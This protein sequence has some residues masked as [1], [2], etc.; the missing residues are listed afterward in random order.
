MKACDLW[1]HL[2]CVCLLLN[3]DPQSMVFSPDRFFCPKCFHQKEQDK[4]PDIIE[5]GSPTTSALDVQ[6]ELDNNDQKTETTMINLGMTGDTV[7]EFELVRQ[8]KYN[9]FDDDMVNSLVRNLHQYI[10]D[11]DIEIRSAME[12]FATV[13]DVRTERPLE[14]WKLVDANDYIT[15]GQQWFQTRDILGKQHTCHAPITAAL[16]SMLRASDGKPLVI[17]ASLKNLPFCQVHIG[18]V[19]WFVFDIL[20]NGIDLHELPNMRSMRAMMTAV[21]SAGEASKHTRILSR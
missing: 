21:A 3:E 18:L 6:S 12:R 7:I 8:E 1:C 4:K 20:D 17:A 2:A 10:Y 14:A 5:G 15:T 16:R 9:G 13:S 11:Y 19:S